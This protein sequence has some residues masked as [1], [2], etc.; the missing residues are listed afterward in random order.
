MFASCGSDTK[1]R[2]YD[3]ATRKLKNE[4]TGGEKEDIGHVNRVYCVKFNPDDENI[5]VTGGWDQTVKVWDIRGNLP[6]HNLLQIQALSTP[7]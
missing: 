6:F 4:L 7:S 1:V 3:E 5:L 2:V